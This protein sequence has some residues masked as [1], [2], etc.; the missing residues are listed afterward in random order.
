MLHGLG[1][2]KKCVLIVVLC[3]VFLDFFYEHILTSP[4]TPSIAVG[5]SC[6]RFLRVYIILF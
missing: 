2:F 1:V 6:P 5:R 4:L 3:L